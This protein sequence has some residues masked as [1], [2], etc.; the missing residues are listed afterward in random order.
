MG[1]TVTF[2]SRE[3]PGPDWDF[4]GLFVGLPAILLLFHL[5]HGVTSC[6]NVF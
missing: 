6:L 5:I 2:Y 3:P 1:Y 4:L